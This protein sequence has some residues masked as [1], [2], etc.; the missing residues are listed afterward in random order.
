MKAEIKEDGF[1]HLTVETVE[2]S[3]TMSY[4]MP[5]NDRVCKECGQPKVPVLVIDNFLSKR[6]RV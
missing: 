4:L 6:D 2:E 5:V 1:I 3:F